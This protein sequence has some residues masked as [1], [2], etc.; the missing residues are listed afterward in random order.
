MQALATH[1]SRRTISR[2]NLAPIVLFL[3]AL[4]ILGAPRAHGMPGVQRHE[5]RNEIYQL[6][7]AWRNAILKSDTAAMDSLLSDDYI[8][9]TA[10]GTLQTKDETLASMRS[11]RLRITH[12]RISD[13]KLRF[14]GHTALV[15]SI[16]QVEGVNA[17]GSINGHFR[18]TRVYVRNARG[19]WKIVSFEASRIRTSPDM[20]Q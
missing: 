14:Y 2:R 11:G 7:N 16:A 6:E 13:R 12:L 18:Y 5:L 20:S 8:A 10:S 17:N 9:I 4:P 19:E 1:C 15:T 3:L